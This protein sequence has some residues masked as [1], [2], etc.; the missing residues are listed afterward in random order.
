[1]SRFGINDLDRRLRG[2]GDRD[3]REAGPVERA[4]TLQ[5]LGLGGLVAVAAVL[6]CFA[7]AAWG[8]GEGALLAVAAILA[9]TFGLLLKRRQRFDRA[10][11]AERRQLRIAVNNI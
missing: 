4:A 5:W 7:L 10:L 8:L 2:D 3:A 1:M 11:A 6:A 9:L